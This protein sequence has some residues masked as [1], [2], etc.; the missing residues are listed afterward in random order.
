MTNS[1]YCNKENDGLMMTVDQHHRLRPTAAATTTTTGNLPQEVDWVESVVNCA[2]IVNKIFT[3]NTCR[4][5]HIYSDK[6]VEFEQRLLQQETSDW[7]TQMIHHTAAAY[8]G[9]SRMQNSNNNSSSNHCNPQ[10]IELYR[11]FLFDEDSVVDSV[12]FRAGHAGSICSSNDGSSN[13]QNHDHQDTTL[14]ENDASCTTAVAT[15]IVTESDL[16]I[17]EA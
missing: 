13:S 7:T 4:L 17:M 11:Q 2:Q 16:N 3:R 5:C 10:M 14:T 15:S 8:S 9:A 1:D 6:Q 12:E